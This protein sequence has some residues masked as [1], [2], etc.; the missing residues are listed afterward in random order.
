M[1]YLSDFVFKSRI[2]FL[3]TEVRPL[4]LLKSGFAFWDGGAGN[5]SSSSSNN[6]HH[7][8]FVMLQ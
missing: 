5:S 8:L 4:W 2:L 6:D 1:N 7:F 3:S